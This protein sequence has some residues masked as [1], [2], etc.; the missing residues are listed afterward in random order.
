MAVAAISDGLRE[1][2]PHSSPSRHRLAGRWHSNCRSMGSSWFGIR[3]SSGGWQ[4]SSCCWRFHSFSLRAVSG[5]RS[6]TR[7]SGS[8]CSTPRT[9]WARALAP[10][11]QPGCCFCCLRKNRSGS[12]RSPEQSL[13]CCR[14][15]PRI[16]RFALPA[17][18]MLGDTTRAALV[19]CAAHHRVQGTA[20]GACGNRLRGRG[21]VLESLWAP[22]DGPQRA[23]S[24]CGM[25]R[26]AAW[27]RRQRFRHSSLSSRT[28]M[29]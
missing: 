9:W 22:H 11:S 2:V 13:L 20:A 16:A 12:R 3:F 10:G 4:G 7:R 18:A 5:S 14:S 26:A 28:A 21:R 25:H 29:E 15:A 6:C 8:P 17:L 24:P 27:S 19:A 23:R 1:L